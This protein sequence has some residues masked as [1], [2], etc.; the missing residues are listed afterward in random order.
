MLQKFKLLTVDLPQ[1]PVD[2]LAHVCA[3][4]DHRVDHALLA[5]RLPL[6]VL[7]GAGP[8]AGPLLV[9]VQLTHDDAPE[10]AAVR[11]LLKVLVKLR[12][13]AHLEDGN[14]ILAKN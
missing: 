2:V 11:P 4:L 14:T 8:Q 12:P 7:P 5:R 13:A 1:P 6:E 9:R 10:G 3:A